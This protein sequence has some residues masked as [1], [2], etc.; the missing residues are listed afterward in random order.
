MGF[1]SFSCSFFGIIVT[2][3]VFAQVIRWIQS[4]ER[5]LSEDFSIPGR[6]QDA[7]ELKKNHEQFQTAIEVQLQHCTDIS[8]FE[9][10]LFF[11]FA[12]RNFA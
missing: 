5:M 4:A 3:F 8:I 12:K 6:L 1:L 11:T 7:E 10:V 2:F 9:I